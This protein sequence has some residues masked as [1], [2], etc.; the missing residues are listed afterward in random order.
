MKGQDAMFEITEK[1]KQ[2][3]LNRHQIAYEA[4]HDA[5]LEWSTGQYPRVKMTP[6]RVSRRC[7]CK[8]NKGAL[9][10]HDVCLKCG[11]RTYNSVVSKAIMNINKELMKS[12]GSRWGGIYEKY[13]ITIMSFYYV[14]RIPDTENGIQIAKVS[15]TLNGGKDATDNEH[16]VWKVPHYVEI[17]PGQPVKAYKV[18]KA[19]DKEMDLF[20]AFGIN[21]TFAKQNPN[22]AYEGSNGMIDFVLKNKKFNQ[23]TGFMDCFNLVE[24]N[25]GRDA[26]F[27]LYMYIYS[28]YPV[29][30]QIVKMGYT[31]VIAQIMRTVIGGYNKTDIRQKAAEL[32]KVMNPEATS[33]S[34]AFTAPK[35]VTTVLN[36]AQAPL[37]DYIMWG[38]VYQIDEHM[39]KEKFMEAYG[40]Y[41]YHRLGHGYSSRKEFPNIMKYGYSVNEIT[42]YLDKQFNKQTDDSTVGQLWNWFHDYLNMCDLL[43]VTPD[44]FPSDIKS[45]HDNVAKAYSAKAN[46][47]TDKKLSAIAANA[48]KLIP[49]T[50]DEDLYE[51][52]LPKSI[53]DFVQEGQNMHNCVGSY[54]DRVSNGHSLVFF[55][56]K[57]DEP[58]A[59]FVTA[60]YRSH[61]I[62]QLYYKNNRRVSD[63]EIIHMANKFKDALNA[64][65]NFRYIN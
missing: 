43:G 46:A 32:N 42:K 26:Y 24:A 62:T 14:K 64:S 52:R 16:L 36:D 3:I 51:I 65:V 55:I 44:K 27:L 1:E 18:L 49:Q 48:E 63:T 28:E 53:Y 38:D 35:Y 9:L 23:Y 37:S 2:E 45:A 40:S 30:E 10:A 21:S 54:V 59:S 58:D 11:Q 6:R 50:K 39:T 13:E 5:K 29:V 31:K 34:S 22:V 60:E 41:S 4:I 25:I 57:K 20:E 15:L 61:N 7:W 8:G 33:G 17:I 19:G 47:L 12:V 56:R